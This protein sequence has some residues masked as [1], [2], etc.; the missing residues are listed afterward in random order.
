MHQDFPEPSPESII[1]PPP[2]EL[3]AWQAMI[4]RLRNLGMLERVVP[5]V[6]VRR[7]G[8]YLAF[9][10]F[11][12]LTAMFFTGN[13]SIKAFAQRIAT[14]TKTLGA[15]AGRVRLP[16]SSSI[17]RVLTALRPV[18]TQ[19]IVQPVLRAVPGM[20]AA[21]Q[22]PQVQH[23]DTLGER[24][25]VFHYDPTRVAVRQRGLPRA[26]EGPEGVRRLDDVA[27]PGHTGRKRG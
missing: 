15:T 14:R 21:L 17:T 18:H 23:Q 6:R 25:H 20:A 24:W 7:A 11:L 12:F 8:G 3:Q 16:S 4:L 27:A 26:E 5:E 2:A 1:P 9:D 22:R 19:A 10:A 13:I